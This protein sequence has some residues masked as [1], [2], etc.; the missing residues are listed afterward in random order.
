VRRR[1][2]GDAAYS[3]S[4]SARRTRWRNS[5]PADPFSLLL[6]SLAHLCRAPEFDDAASSSALL[7]SSLSLLM[8]SSVLVTRDGGCATPLASPTPL[9][10]APA[11]RPSYSRSGD[12]L[13]QRPPIIP[14][15]SALRIKMER[16]RAFSVGTVTKSHRVTR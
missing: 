5:P 4:R 1:R 3:W 2:A 9:P 10:V 11:A 16:S 14:T 12:G 8:N 13:E 15:Q 6:S 7:L